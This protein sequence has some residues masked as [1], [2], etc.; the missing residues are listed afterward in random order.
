MAKTQTREERR[1]ELLAKMPHD[2]IPAKPMPY[3]AITLE[4]RGM[5]KAMKP[6]AQQA[7]LFIALLDYADD[8]S[9]SYDP[10]LLLN[11][12]GLNPMTAEI[13]K[14]MAVKIKEYADNYRIE[15]FG[16]SKANGGGRPAKPK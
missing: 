13:G 5:I 15:S 16:K 4:Q 10:G 1:T 8:Y 3:A 9:R 12:D 11:V 2:Y 6:P 14:M 7:K